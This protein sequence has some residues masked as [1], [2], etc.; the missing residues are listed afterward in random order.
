MSTAIQDTMVIGT[1]LVELCRTGENL[2]AI[3]TLYSDDV[4]SVEPVANPAFEQTIT[5]I[6]K[7]KSKN[8]WWYENNELHAAELDGPYPHGDRFIVAMK[9][10][11][12]PKAGP[13]AGNRFT[14][15][16]M[17][18]YTVAGKKIVKEEFYY[19]MD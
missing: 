18:L 12:T 7:V 15:R 14:M 19:S 10:D 13:M 16:E 5:G 2:T 4:V 11:V 6:D 1:K 17:G 8:R 9:Y 3:E